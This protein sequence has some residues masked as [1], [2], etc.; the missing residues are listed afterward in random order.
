MK[1]IIYTITLIALF[2]FG[3]SK[4]T[5]LTDEIKAINPYKVGQRLVFE[6][7]DGLRNI[8]K[9]TRVEENRFP[10]GLGQFQNERMVIIGFRESQ[11]IKYGT[12]ERIMT[13]I[14]KDDTN[15]GRIDFSISL[16]DTYLR[17]DYIDADKF[18]KL[19]VMSIKTPY[20]SYDD[21][22]NMNNTSQRK[23]FDDEIVEFFWSKSIG[24]V[25]LIQQNGIVW[26]LV[27]LDIEP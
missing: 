20:S 10:Q 17:M 23:I 9:I 26:E 7:S 11:S 16:K 8:I 14:A 19:S 4:K 1:I 2:I 5:Y 25:R 22:V 21:V 27:D 12:E 15:M 18:N 6:S 13:L 24:Y 3:C